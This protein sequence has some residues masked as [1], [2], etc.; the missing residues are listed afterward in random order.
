[1][2]KNVSFKGDMHE[3][4]RGIRQKMCACN[5]RTQ[6]WFPFHRNRLLPTGQK[7]LTDKPFSCI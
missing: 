1:M 7:D 2:C 6:W 3:K 4:S 5:R